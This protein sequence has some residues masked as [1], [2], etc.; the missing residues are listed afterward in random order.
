LIL[1]ESFHKIMG[2]VKLY[3]LKTSVG[4]SMKKLLLALLFTMLL[5]LVIGITQFA[6]HRSGISKAQSRA[7]R[8]CGEFLN[9]DNN[10]KIVNIVKSADH[11]DFD[12]SQGAA[13]VHHL[14][15]STNKYF[16]VWSGLKENDN[17]MISF[18]EESVDN[19]HPYDV[20]AYECPEN[21]KDK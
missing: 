21:Q 12:L 4:G 13:S 20:E 5:T 11:I 10:Y 1:W 6:G 18:S 16:S 17:I 2:T 14:V 8:E 3:K 7:F 19:N 9:G 15:W